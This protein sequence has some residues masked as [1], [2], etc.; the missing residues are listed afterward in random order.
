MSEQTI[1]AV[2]HEGVFH[3]TTPEEVALPEGQKV[4][5]SIKKIE[6]ETEAERAA[7]SERIL[8]L[9]DHF[10][11]GLSEEEIAKIESAMRRRPNFFGEDEEDEGRFDPNRPT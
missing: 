1:T 4:E 11:D 10:Y 9:L 5:L 3:P 6:E 8:N 7:R 2:Y